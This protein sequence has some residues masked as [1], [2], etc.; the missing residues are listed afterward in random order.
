MIIRIFTA[1]IV[2]GSHDLWLDKVEKFSIPW[3][4]SQPGLIAYYPG[5]P[6][7]KKSRE[8]SMTSIWENRDALKNAVGDD[9]RQVILLEDETALVEE[10]SVAHYEYF[11][12]SRHISNDEL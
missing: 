10:T 11:D 2:S 8:F 3:L 5:R 4:I 12:V 1:R 9:W 6:L 7:D